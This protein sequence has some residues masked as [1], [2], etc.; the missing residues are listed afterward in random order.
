MTEGRIVGK[1]S[2]PRREWLSRGSESSLVTKTGHPL[3][4][5]APLVGVVWG[6][7]EVGR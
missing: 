1:F 6:E 4:S 7:G 3:A 2:H 5:L